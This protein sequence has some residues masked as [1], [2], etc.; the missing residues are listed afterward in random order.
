MFPYYVNKGMEFLRIQDASGIIRSFWQQDENTELFVQEWKVHDGIKIKVKGDRGQYVG[1]VIEKDLGKGRI[2]SSIQWNKNSPDEELSSPSN[3]VGKTYRVFV[4]GDSI[5]TVSYTGKY[6]K[7]K[8]YVYTEWNEKGKLRSRGL[9]TGDLKIMYPFKIF[10]ND[11]TMTE[12]EYDYDMTSDTIKADTKHEIYR[13]KYVNSMKEGYPRKKDQSGRGNPKEDT[14]ENKTPESIPSSDDEENNAGFIPSSNGNENS[15]DIRG[16]MSDHLSPVY[17][18]Y[19]NGEDGGHKDDDRNGEERNEMQENNSQVIQY[20]SITKAAE[21]SKDCENIRL[22]KCPDL[23]GFLSF[24]QFSNSLL[25]VVIDDE[26][27]NKVIS[28]SFSSMNK[29]KSI[30]IGSRS[31]TKATWLKIVKCG[32]LESL[33]IGPGSFKNATSM[34]VTDCSNLKSI[35]VGDENVISDNFMYCDELVLSGE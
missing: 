19:N 11:G 6:D 13:G 28:V 12:C 34:K 24:T 21:I 27:L 33:K 8:K 7:N 23:R 4:A 2:K 5:M 18:S 32:N 31:L 15:V 3:V 1:D 29:L 22:M 25:S 14:S 30:T 10:E 17:N 20:S 9:I 26:S 35:S 16:S